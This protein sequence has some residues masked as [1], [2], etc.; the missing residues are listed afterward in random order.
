[1]ME[2]SRERTLRQL[3]ENVIR[4]LLQ[5]CAGVSILTSFGILGILLFESLPFFEEVSPWE[6]LTGTNWAPLMEPR[7][8]GV[9]PLI[10]GTL[11]VTGVAAVLVIPI[12][13]LAAMYLSEYASPKSRKR[14]KPAL[15]V[16][17]GIPT[18]VY[19]YF[20]VIVVTPALRT[21]LPNASVFNALSAGIVVAIM[22]IPT[23]ATPGMAWE[24]RDVR[25]PSASSSPARSP[26]SSPRTS[27]PS[28]GR[29]VRR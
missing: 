20:A 25:S 7:H 18:V 5:L 3:R 23:C 19:G 14:L 22:I 6:F 8:F 27:S 15:E 24:P 21:V 10:A 12:G 1:M 29:S 16:L 11:L 17:A 28:A 9:V 26:A 13:S 2:P 4:F